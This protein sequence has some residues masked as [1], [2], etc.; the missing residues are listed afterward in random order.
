VSPKVAFD[1]R[2]EMV[3]LNAMRDALEE[4]LFIEML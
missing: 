3:T 2:P 1:R 4:L